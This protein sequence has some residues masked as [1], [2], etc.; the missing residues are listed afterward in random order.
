MQLDWNPQPAY[1]DFVY[2]SSK[3]IIKRRTLFKDELVYHVP[4][5]G[6]GSGKTFF[7]SDAVIVEGSIRPIRVL[8]TRELQNSIEDSIKAELEEAISARGLQGFYTITKNRIVG[9]NGTEFMF[10]GLK[11]NINNIKSISNVDIVLCEEAENISK[12]SWSKLLPS[13]RPRN[14]EVRDSPIV[15]VIFNPA[16]E[17]DDTYQ[18]FVVNPPGRCLSKLINWSENIYFPDFLNQLRLD[19]KRTLPP[20]EYD[21]IWE[22]KTTGQSGDVIIRKEWIR[23][24]RFA[25]KNEDWKKVGSKVIAY[26]PAGQGRDFNAIAYKDGN[27]VP[28]VD[29]WLISKD[30]RE[31]TRRAFLPAIENGVDDFVYDE[32]GGFGDGIS[33]FVDDITD[34]KDQSM[35]DMGYGAQRQIEIKPFNAGAAVIDADKA[36][37]EGELADEKNTWGEV[38]TNAKAQAHGITAQKLYTTYRFIALGERDMK[39]EEM[40][41][42]DIEDDVLFNKLTLELSTPLWV[43]SGTNSKKKVEDK[44]AMEKRTELPSPNIADAVHMLNAK[45]EQGF[46]PMAW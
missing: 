43:R 44:K 1:R 14:L 10:R 15:I 17:L 22:G 40:L 29:E 27:T 11:N 46:T 12:V 4:Y 28:F 23:A 6:R 35:I 38:Y 37:I 16:D 42:L 26:D 8:V 30:L 33:V 36:I 34:G 31:A 18:R 32:C 9:K 39:P 5:G 45:H 25:S 24:A 3:D 13:I 20:D 41:S 19:Q 21:H 2:T 7:Y